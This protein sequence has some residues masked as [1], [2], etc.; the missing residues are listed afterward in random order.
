MAYDEEKYAQASASPDSLSNTSPERATDGKTDVHATVAGRTSGGEGV[1]EYN[2]TPVKQDNGIFSK[3][4][5]FEAALD[6]KLGIESQA[7]DR[8]LPEDKKPSHGIRRLSWHCY[9][10]V[11]QCRSRVS[12]LDSLAGNSACH[13][14]RASSSQFLV[15]SSELWF[16]DGVQQ[17]ALPLD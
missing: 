5:S 13:C 7:I 12:L 3:M 14:R 15:H 10:Q 8:V 2:S 4:R 6:R 17:W 9:G 11:E 16:L 1:Q